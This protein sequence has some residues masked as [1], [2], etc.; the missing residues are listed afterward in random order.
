[1]PGAAEMALAATRM[2]W[3]TKTKNKEAKTKTRTLSYRFLTVMTL[4]ALLSSPSP[5]PLLLAQ[6]PSPLSPATARSD[7]RG[8]DNRLQPLELDKFVYLP[9]VL[10]NYM[11]PTVERTQPDEKGEVEVDLPSGGT[12]LFSNS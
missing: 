2:E 10:N 11:P 12:A 3:N 6:R 4:L 8:S 5:V 7:Q 1:M 9:L